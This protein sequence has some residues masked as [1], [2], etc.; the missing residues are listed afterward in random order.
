MREAESSLTQ[1]GQLGRREEEDGGGDPGRDGLGDDEDDGEDQDSVGGGEDVGEETAQCPAGG[2]RL[3]VV[4]EGR[5]VE[6]QEGDQETE[7]LQP[8]RGPV[9]GRSAHIALDGKYY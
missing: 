6:R 9:Q 3:T 7:H 1:T 4:V 2:A 5:G 8:G